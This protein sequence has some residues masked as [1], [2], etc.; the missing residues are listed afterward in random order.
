MGKLMPQIRGK[1]DGTL[2]NEMATVYLESL[3]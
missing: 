2:V 3:S 1:A